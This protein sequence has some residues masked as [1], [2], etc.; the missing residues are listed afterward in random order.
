VSHVDPLIQGHWSGRLVPLPRGQASVYVAD[1]PG[2][3]QHRLTN[4]GR[5][6]NLPGRV[7][8]S[9]TPFH[10]RIID[11]SRAGTRTGKSQG[12]ETASDES[13]S[14][15]DLRSREINELAGQFRRQ[16]GLWRNAAAL[17][18]VSSGVA[19]G[20][21]GLC[22]VLSCIRSSR[23]ARRGSAARWAHARSPQ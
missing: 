19:L 14:R 11:L 16:G 20:S 17:P 6:S 2:P 4:G 1:T 3:H 9:I 15:H 12:G 10:H 5:V 23:L 21:V 8:R 13:I 18:R 7:P 22:R